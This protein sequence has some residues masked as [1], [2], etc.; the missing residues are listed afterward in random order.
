MAIFGYI[1]AITYLYNTKGDL[2]RLLFYYL[3]MQNPYIYR[4]YRR[5]FVAIVQLF[6]HFLRYCKRTVNVARDFYIIPR[7]RT[8]FKYYRLTALCG[9]ISSFN[10]I[11][12]T[13]VNVR[14]RFI[15]ILNRNSQVISCSTIVIIICFISLV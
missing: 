8:W 15:A 9:I 11:P 10:Q 6:I 1:K 13:I 14:N 5:S 2:Y 3:I 12:I 4:V 7:I